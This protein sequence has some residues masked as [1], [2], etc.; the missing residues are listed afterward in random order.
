MEYWVAPLLCGG[1]PWILVRKGGLLQLWVAGHA[2][3]AHQ[4]SS[5]AFSAKESGRR[6]K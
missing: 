4:N 2:F 3:V 6:K 1:Y 5:K